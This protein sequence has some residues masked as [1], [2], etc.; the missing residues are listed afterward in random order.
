MNKY[1]VVKMSVS[2]WIIDFAKRVAQLNSFVNTVDYQIKGVWLGG[3]MFPEAFMTAT[4]Q[5]VAQNNGW[6]L[7]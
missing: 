2:E 4:R 7:E 5:F 3:M 1:V 6:S